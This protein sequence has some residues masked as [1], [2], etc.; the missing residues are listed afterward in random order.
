M[1]HIGQICLLVYSL[2]LLFGGVLGFV[3]GKSTISLFSGLGSA[4]AAFI[5]F[6]LSQT[7][8]AVGFGIGI[9]VGLSLTVVFLSRFRKTGKFMPSGLLSVVSILA[10][11]I[12]GIA[13]V[14][15]GN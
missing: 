10:A 8:P 7:N 4:V 12:S 13:L 15:P 14:Q 1:L 3:K 11:L 9:G 6:W 5:G 2:L